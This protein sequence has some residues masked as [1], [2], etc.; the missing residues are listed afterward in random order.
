LIVE[1][2]AQRLRNFLVAATELMAV[3]ARACGHDALARFAARDLTSWKREIADLAGVRY[4]GP[5][6]T[7]QT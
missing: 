1:E 2:S 5:V 3:L 4:A 7:T 6:P